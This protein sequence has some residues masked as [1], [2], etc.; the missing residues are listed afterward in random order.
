MGVSN[1]DEDTL[2]SR[3]IVVATPEKLDFALRNDPSILDDVGISHSRRGTHDW[4]R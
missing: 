4:T 1:F 2:R 3:D